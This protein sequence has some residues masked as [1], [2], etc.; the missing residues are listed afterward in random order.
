V[1][2]WVQV[3]NQISLSVRERKT[4]FCN[5]CKSLKKDFYRVDKKIRK[6]VIGYYSPCQLSCTYCYANALPEDKNNAVFRRIKL[7]ALVEQ[8]ESLNLIAG[9]ALIACAA[10]EITIAP[11]KKE[12]YTLGQKYRL[13]A[14]TNAVIFDQ[15]LAT[16]VARNSSTISVSP[17]AGT[18]ETYKLIKGLD[19]F[20]EVWG[21]IEKYISNGV[22][23]SVKY[24][25]LPENS[26]D[27]DVEGFIQKIVSVGVKHIILSSEYRQKLGTQQLYAIDKMSQ[28]C[29]TH[30]ISVDY[31][32]VDQSFDAEYVNNTL[33]NKEMIGGIM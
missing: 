12:V 2:E 29:K 28:L 33:K 27:A 10:G 23:V 26:N 21:N 22:L 15:E 20:E 24:I 13:Y 18:R 31:N 30:N 32:T 3:R 16:I 5:G 1:L 25:F 4:N 17:D 14:A 7:T 11:Y 6:L 9:D 8:L 19:A